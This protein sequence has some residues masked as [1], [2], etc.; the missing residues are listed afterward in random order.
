MQILLIFIIRKNSR[1]LIVSYVTCICVCE[2]HSFVKNH[3]KSAFVLKH[4]KKIF[5]NFF[6]IFVNFAEIAN[7]FTHFQ[8]TGY[9]FSIYDTKYT[10]W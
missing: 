5:T 10:V 2:V 8:T 6:T 9:E 4:V 1:F 7:F 3:C